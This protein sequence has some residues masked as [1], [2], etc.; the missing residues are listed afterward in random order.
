MALSEERLRILKMIE[1]GKIS[2]EEGV[3][4]L[5]ALRGGERN[6]AAP[7]CPEK[8]WFRVRITDIRSGEVKLSVNVP[9]RLVQVGARMGARLVPKIKG[10]EIDEIMERIHEGEEGKLVDVVDPDEKERFEVI[11]E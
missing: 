5:D 2:S 9:L 11:V 6:P 10:V 4:L 1:E 3:K 7:C 8:R